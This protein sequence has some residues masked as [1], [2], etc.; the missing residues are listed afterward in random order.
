MTKKFM[1]SVADV[2]IYDQDNDNL[3]AIGKTL[4]DSSLDMTLSNTDIRGGRGN[5]LLSTY[6]HTSNLEIKV[7][8]TQFNLDFLALAVGSDV[9]TGDSVYTEENVTLGVGGAGTVL[10][11]PIVVNS[12]TVYG[13]LTLPDEAGV[14]KVTFT[15]QNFTSALAAEGDI[16]CVRYYNVNSAARSLTISSEILP[17]VVRVEMETLLIS[18][19]QTT[20]RIGIVQILIP[21]GTLT[22]NFSLSMSSDGVSTT[23]L[24]VRALANQALQSA[25]CSTAPV[26]AKIIEIL[27]DSTWYT[28]VVGLS[29]VGGDFAM[30]HPS[31]KS[32]VVYALPSV[33]AAF[34]APV[35]DLTFSSATVGTATINSAGL[36]TTV[37]AG[38]S[39]L[40]AS[41]T[42]KTSIDANVIVTVS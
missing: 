33:G 5:P 15:G 10:G 20:N 35:A 23:P 19:Q 25:A 9:V 36:V 2:R 6:Y 24:T 32:L 13:W 17:K 31:T 41:I 14:E 34:L 38:T 42:Q 22:G 3:I 30:T 16:V 12:T 1:V 39:V 28:D 8:E 26:L 29:I 4:I 11:T 18:S 37:A 27:D 40:K 21:T 7:T